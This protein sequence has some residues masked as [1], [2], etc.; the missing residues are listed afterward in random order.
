MR[1][2]VFNLILWQGYLRLPSGLPWK[3]SLFH[4]IRLEFQWRLG[5]LGTVFVLMSCWSSWIC[6]LSRWY[7]LCVR[8][9][10]QFEWL[11]ED[12]WG[13]SKTIGSSTLV[14]WP[15]RVVYS[16]YT[17]IWKMVT[18]NGFE[19]ACWTFRGTLCCWIRCWQ[20]DILRYQDLAGVPCYEQGLYL[21]VLFGKYLCIWH[22]LVEALVVIDGGLQ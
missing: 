8:L 2:I 1:F 22:E 18:I 16:V 19:W 20:V 21:L 6:N 5:A 9:V 7:T 12:P 17:P 3:N 14:K 11:P 15:N 4:S 13:T 10:C